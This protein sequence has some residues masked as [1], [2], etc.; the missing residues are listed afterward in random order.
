VDWW[1]WWRWWWWWCVHQ[2]GG[3]C[4]PLACEGFLVSPP[5]T[6][7]ISYLRATAAQRSVRPSR[8]QPSICRVLL[9][10][11][12]SPRRLRDVHKKT[13]SNVMFFRN[14]RAKHRC[15]GLKAFRDLN[16]I[17]LRVNGTFVSDVCESFNPVALC[18]KTVIEQVRL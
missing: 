1:R 2:G 12:L 3:I 6:S 10:L 11:H 16:S 14:S 13:T 18:D 4:Q 8:P 7:N 9:Y 17:W 15:L 5:L